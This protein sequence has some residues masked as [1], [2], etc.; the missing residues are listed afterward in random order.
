MK[1][2]PF[3]AL[4]IALILSLLLNSILTRSIGEPPT[5]TLAL[6]GDVMLG[7][8]VA[9][10]HTSGGW[11]EIF[12]PIAPELQNADL[13]LANLESPL[14]ID[15]VTIQDTTA[16]Y[17]L[18]APAAATAALT[19]AGLDILSIANNHSADCSPNALPST[20]A[21]LLRA[22]MA[23]LDTAYQPIQRSIRGIE[24]AFL[25]FDDITSPLDLDATCRAVSGAHADGS[26]V[27]ISIH[28]GNEFQGAASP[29]QEMLAQ[30][31]ADC[32]AAL[33]WGHH[34]HVLQPVEWIQ[35]ANQPSPTLVLFSLGN[36]VFDQFSPPD[37]A[38]SA[39]LLVTL[40][41]GGVQSWQALPF[42]IDALAGKIK[43]AD[44]VISSAVLHR[45]GLEDH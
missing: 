2:P 1:K 6:L 22:G 28:W 23:P 5:L 33:I 27:V 37:A 34:P 16:G 18:C 42:K 8:G 25:A 21:I 3:R 30:L 43:K 35:G 36:A 45:L 13:A 17:N 39:L 14:S 9:Q 44:E 4:L 41:A 12:A 40:D 24:L 26:L 7:R 29:R 10:A 19:A 11:D 15:P 38:R 32:G 31:L 20:P